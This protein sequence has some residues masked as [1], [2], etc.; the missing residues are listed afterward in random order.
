MKDVPDDIRTLHS[1]TDVRS[2]F[3]LFKLGPNVNSVELKY[4][5][6]PYD[7]TFDNEL[8]I[9]NN[10][11]VGID[12]PRMSDSLDREA[13]DINISDNDHLLRTSLD[14]WNMFGAPF[15]VYLG[16]INTTDTTIDGAAPN[17]PLN[18]KFVAYEGYVDTYAYS[19]TPDEEIILSIEGSSPMSA[20][21]LT[22]TLLTSKAYIREK[23]PTDSCFDE[24][25]ESSD[26]VTVK[27]GK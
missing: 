13:F 24:V 1:M 4:T 11:I 21:D 20:L 23:Y 16:Y 15:K 8:Y 7:H 17:T 9:S 10:G 5:T 18:G 22:R 6:L 14:T 25:T 19:I 2:E 3:Y 27:W 26:V 12:Q